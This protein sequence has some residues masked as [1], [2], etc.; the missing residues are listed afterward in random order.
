[1][2]ILGIDPGTT[3][4][5]FAAVSCD[6]SG[7]LASD[8]GIIEVRS[9]TQVERLMELHRG[10]EKIIRSCRPHAVA[11]ERL[12]FSKNV[13][14]ALPVAESRGVILLTTA[15][16]GTILHEYTPQ[17]VKL[18]VTGDGRADK[19]QV[20]KMVRMSLSGGRDL[21]ATDDVFDAI[22]I[23]VTCFWRE[24]AKQKRM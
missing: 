18:A 7:F 16:A 4:A 13:K 20:R 9:P 11:V 5:G 1:M 21:K 15:L 14:T 6:H 8:T 24:Y 10:L 22:A 17:E 12:F 3:R 23:A 2:I 19:A